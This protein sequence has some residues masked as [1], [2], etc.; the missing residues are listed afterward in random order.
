MQKP[1]VQAN[2]ERRL[3]G[4]KRREE[5]AVHQVLQRLHS[6]ILLLP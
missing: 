6:G 3:D 2:Y 4:L 5:R 1:A